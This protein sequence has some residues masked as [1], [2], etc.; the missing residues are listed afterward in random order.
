MITTQ[1]FRPIN[2]N[3]KLGID[4]LQSLDKELSKIKTQVNPKDYQCIAAG[5]YIIIEC[6]YHP[7]GKV[8]YK[9]PRKKVDYEFDKFPKEYQ[10]EV[11][12]LQ[13]ELNL[14]KKQVKNLYKIVKSFNIQIN[15]LE[16]RLELLRNNAKQLKNEENMKKHINNFYKSYEKFS[17]YLTSDLASYDSDTK[18]E[19]KKELIKLI[20]LIEDVIDKYLS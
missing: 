15:N 3:E 5:G 2:A 4:N 9:T 10:K 8:T 14:T 7:D 6:K 12:K 17:E 13:S 20:R 11:K 18:N 19:I 1:V 16:K